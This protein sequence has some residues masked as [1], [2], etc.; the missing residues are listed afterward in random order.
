LVGIKALG[1]TA[2]LRPLQLLDDRLQAL[3]LA[4]AV[5]D[6]GSHIANETLQKGRFGSQIVEIE[7]M[8]EGT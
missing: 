4:V 6:G 3:D 1:P 7:R 8:S 5:L 2:E